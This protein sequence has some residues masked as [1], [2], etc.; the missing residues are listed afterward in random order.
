MTPDR[1]LVAPEESPDPTHLPLST[2]RTPQPLIPQETFP[3]NSAASAD[4]DDPGRKDM[5]PAAENL[6]K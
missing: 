4:T 6:M 3:L 5:S 1:A 2:D